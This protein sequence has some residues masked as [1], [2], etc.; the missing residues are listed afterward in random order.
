MSTSNGSTPEL[1]KKLEEGIEQV[2][3]SERFREYLDT[4][5]RFH[6]YSLG[7]QILIAMQRPAATRVAGFHTWLGMDRHVNKGEKGIKILAPVTYKRQGEDEDDE[8]EMAV[9]FRT[10]HVFDVSQ[11]DGK[12]LPEI[13][14]HLDGNDGALYDKLAAIA[15]AEGLTIE[16]EPKNTTA[17]GYYTGKTIWISPELAPTMAVKTFVHEL[18]HHFAGHTGS[19]MQSRS[20][21]E[22][23][24]ESVAYVVL[25]HFGIDSSQYSFDSWPHGRRTRRYSRASWPR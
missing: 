8:P 18:A 1:L 3:N 15:I 16:R 17:N 10:V 9:T 21:A 12:A 2:R 19:C 13:A 5:A 24:V 6:N 20:V 25:G 22:T 7:N 4:C 14:R 23:I 11:T